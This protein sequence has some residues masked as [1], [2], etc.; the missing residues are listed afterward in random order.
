MFKQYQRQIITFALLVILGAAFARPHHVEAVV[1]QSV[2]VPASELSGVTAAD[3]MQLVYK[4][5]FAEKV[6][7]PGG[8]RLYAY[9]GIALHEAVVPGIEGGKS[10]SGQV[11]D[12]PPMP[13]IEEGVDDYIVKPIEEQKIMKKIQR[14]FPRV[15]TLED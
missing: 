6:S 15:G 1:L 9:A 2:S 14:Y 8:G 13:A 5:V 4:R 12:L 7:A 11:T 3:W 10:L